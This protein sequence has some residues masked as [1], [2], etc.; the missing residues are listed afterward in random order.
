MDIKI[1]TKMVVETTAHFHDGK[2]KT[3]PCDLYAYWGNETCK[4]VDFNS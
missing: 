2:L 1:K 4:E 3:N